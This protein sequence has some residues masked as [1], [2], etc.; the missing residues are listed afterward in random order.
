M[1]R[2]TFHNHIDSIKEI[3]GLSIALDRK[4]G[5]YKITPL[6]DPESKFK[7]QD[8]ISILALLEKVEG[9]DGARS[10]KLPVIDPEKEAP[11]TVQV[12]TYGDETTYW[13][14][15]PLHSSQKE[16]TTADDYS[17]FSV[18]I[19]P[20]TKEFMEE[21]LSRGDRVEVLQP[22]N[23]REQLA[24]QSDAMRARY[25]NFWQKEKNE[26]EAAEDRPENIRSSWDVA[27]AA[28][29]H[30]NGPMGS[31]VVCTDVYRNN[32]EI[33]AS[34]SYVTGSGKLVCLPGDDDPMLD[35]T[36]LYSEEFHLRKNLFTVFDTRIR[37]TKEN[38]LGAA[39][40]I[41]QQ[42]LNPAVVSWADGD[43]A[44]GWYPLGSHSQEEQLCRVTTLSRSLYQYYTENMSKTVSVPFKGKGYPIATRF[45]GIYSPGVTVFRNESEGFSL[46]DTP[47]RVS[48]I[49]IPALNLRE[50]GSRLSSLREIDAK[51]LS[52]LRDKIRSIYRIALVNGHD[53]IVLDISSFCNSPVVRLFHDILEEDEFAGRFR[54]VAFVTSGRKKSI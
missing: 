2:R 33:F 5:K 3:F 13:R 29:K 31:R 47:Y 32:N 10:R 44:C 19:T 52:E 14:E 51:E 50:H 1:P 34:G 36:T 45:G 54:E 12:K 7:R 11:V 18:E 48:V 24:L 35:G 4:D 27:S 38:S 15:A 20:D 46:L 8:I 53:A 23:I 6:E 21:I 28:E 41:Q 39:R 30:A 9:V 40:R 43:T 25:A 17:V 37:E 16:I 26:T 22:K 49:S 42:H